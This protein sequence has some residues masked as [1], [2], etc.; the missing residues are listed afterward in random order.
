[1]RRV[2]LCLYIE[3]SRYCA[4][5]SIDT[6][7][8]H[9]S[10]LHVNTPLVRHLNDQG[11]IVVAPVAPLLY[12]LC[13]LARAISG[14]LAHNPHCDTSCVTLGIQAIVRIVGNSGIDS[15]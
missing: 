9:G 7:L 13:H 14:H 3:T 12:N 15:F 4:T 8:Q 11:L 2:R 6:S 5:T 1:M 10:H